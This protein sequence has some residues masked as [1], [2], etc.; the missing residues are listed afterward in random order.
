M[1]IYVSFSHVAFNISLRF[2]GTVV[3]LDIVLQSILSNLT[4]FRSERSFLYYP[5]TTAISLA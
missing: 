1:F 3:K 5:I 4:A 2:A